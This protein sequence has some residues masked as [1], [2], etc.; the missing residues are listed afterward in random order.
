MRLVYVRRLAN[1][2]YIK[3]LSNVIWHH[4]CYGATAEEVVS[5]VTKMEI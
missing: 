5:E 2:N 4:T 1:V 3:F